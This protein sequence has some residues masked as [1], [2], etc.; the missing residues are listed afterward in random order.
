MRREVVSGRT[1]A[2]LSGQI[3]SGLTLAGLRRAAGQQDIH[4][5]VPH[6]RPGRSVLAFCVVAFAALLVW[7]RQLNMPRRIPRLLR[8]ASAGD[9][10]TALGC[11]R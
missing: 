10:A 9:T 4:A 6:V 3:L 5:A 1:D 11:S 2:R 7:V 8:A